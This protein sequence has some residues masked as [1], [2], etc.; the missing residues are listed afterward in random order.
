[1]KNYVQAGENITVTAEAAATSG[2][3]V[4]VGTLFGIAS[5]VA[6]IGDSLVLVTEG[7]FEM[8]KV[9]TDDMAVGAAVYWRSSDGLVTTTASGNTKVSVAIMAAGNPS[10]AVR[11][12]LNG[13]F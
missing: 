8:P 3:G 4:R 5:G 1:M 13:T 10:S 2:D 9:A 7:V 11:V 6:E 12:R